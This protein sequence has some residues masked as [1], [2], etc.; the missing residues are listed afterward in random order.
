MRDGIVRSDFLVERRFD[1]K[2]EL[3]KMKD[4]VEEVLEAA[5]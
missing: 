5:S 1:A 4:A 3:V 2:A